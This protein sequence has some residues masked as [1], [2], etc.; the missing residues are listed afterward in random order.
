MYARTLCRCAAMSRRIGQPKVT[1]LAQ[2][3]DV[4]EASI[5][6]SWPSS[7]IQRHLKSA[8]RRLSSAVLILGLAV[9]LL[10]TP[11]PHFGTVVSTPPSSSGSSRTHNQVEQPAEAERFG[12]EFTSRNAA[13][14]P[15]SW[16]RFLVVPEH[17]KSRVKGALLGDFILHAACG[18]QLS[19]SFFGYVP[20][21]VNLVGE[22]FAAIRTVNG[23][24]EPPK[25]PTAANCADPG[26]R[27]WP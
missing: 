1:R 13:A 8:L 21:P 12:G 9:T 15:L 5:S 10:A 24:T 17:Q 23:A 18:G 4:W 19:A 3:L 22:D 27:F 26:L 16:Y 6:P 11:L 25:R 20:L 2:T 14:Y 7:N